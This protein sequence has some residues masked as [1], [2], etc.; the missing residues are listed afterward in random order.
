MNVVAAPLLLLIGPLA[1]EEEPPP[2]P[3]PGVLLVA[4]TIVIVW[5]AIVFLIK[6]CKRSRE[7]RNR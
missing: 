1:H 5:T 2:N 6:Y 4:L 7:L 3:Y